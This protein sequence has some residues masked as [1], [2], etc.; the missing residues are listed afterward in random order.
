MF[1]V[2]EKRGWMLFLAALIVFGIA[3]A[4]DIGPLIVTNST[5][6]PVHILDT[7]GYHQCN[8]LKQMTPSTNMVVYNSAGTAK[9]GTTFNGAILALDTDSRGSLTLDG[10]TEVTKTFTTA[11]ADTNYYILGTLYAGTNSVTDSVGIA[12]QYVGSF[13][14][15]NTACYGSGYKYQWMKIRHTQ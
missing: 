15:R 6:V 13:S 3:Y 14:V 11:E 12:T 10:T 4:S 7:S 5:G 1:K 8:G 9:G 2:W